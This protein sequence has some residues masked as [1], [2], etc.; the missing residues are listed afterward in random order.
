MEFK[1][2]DNVL[3]GKLKLQFSN[4]EVLGTDSGSYEILLYQ[5]GGK[6]V[7]NKDFIGNDVCNNANDKFRDFF[8][9]AK[10]QNVP[11]AVTPEYSCPWIVMKDIV[12]NAD[13][14][15][16]EGK[17]WIVGCESISKKMIIEF[18]KSI[19]ATKNIVLYFDDSILSSGKSFLNPLCYVFRAKTNNGRWVTLLIIQFKTQHCG[20]WS[21]ATEKNNL[22]LGKEVYVLR[23]NQNS[24]KLF[25][26]ICSDVEKFN[27]TPE[28]KASL[29]DSWDRDPFLILNIQFNPKP[30]DSLFLEFRNKILNYSYPYKEIISLNWAEETLPPNTYP[31]TSLHTESNQFNIDER[32]LK[33][34]HERGLY[35]TYRHQDNHSIFF[36]SGAYVFKIRNSQISQVGTYRSMVRNAGPEILDVYK[37][38]SNKFKKE[39]IPLN[40]GFSDYLNSAGCTLR[41]LKDRE[42]SIFDK[43]RLL[44]ISNGTISKG[45]EWF[46]INN[47]KTFQISSI[48]HINRLTFAQD[49]ETK[50]DRFRYIEYMR[51][52]NDEIISNKKYFPK[53]LLKFYH[54]C[55]QVMFFKGATGYIYAYNLV[56]K[57]KKHKAT[58]A[59]IGPN[60]RSS[61][62]RAFGELRNIF[63]DSQDWRNIVVWYSRSG[64]IIS[65]CEPESPSISDQSNVVPNSI[66]KEK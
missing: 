33:A 60:D 64:N 56:T 19:K 1:F 54:N 5:H 12:E 62:R 25:T 42:V 49:H 57:D 9:L 55:D 34:N 8:K 38:V 53:R 44:N 14:Q 50:N 21:D 27:I 26:L 30:R 36:N 39:T 66:V 4:L 16:T 52:L 18:R 20:V 6:I 41:S 47:L 43:E 31:C 40:D 15:P 61:A 59:F 23:N 22:I 63:P 3:K 28:F 45:N 58:V 46:K 17:L 37:W 29:S 48:E 11:L 13:L 24:V 32:F 51:I 65:E 35:Y 2:L 7:A 10:S